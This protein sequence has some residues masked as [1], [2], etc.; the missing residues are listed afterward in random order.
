MEEETEKSSD[1]TRG[2]DGVELKITKTKDGTEKY[3][4]LFFNWDFFICQ[5]LSKSFCLL[6]S[7]IACLHVPSPSPCPL[8][9]PSNLH[10][11]L[12]DGPFDSQN[13]F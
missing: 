7:V 2:N 6:C 3:V 5:M 11:V 4:F 13:G 8:P 9:S 12:S 10:C 1:K